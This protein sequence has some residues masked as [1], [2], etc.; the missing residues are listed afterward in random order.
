MRIYLSESDSVNGQPALTGLITL[1]QQAGVR[2][3][4]VLRGIEGLG[5]H[6]VHSAGFIGLAHQLPLMVEIIDETAQMEKALVFLTPH[7]KN[8]LVATWPVNLP[9][10]EQATFTTGET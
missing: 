1:C 7:I 5:S 9:L 4:S 6:G 2:G 3:V 8:F 10:A